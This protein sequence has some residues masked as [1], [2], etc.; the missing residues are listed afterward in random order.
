M[1][2]ST[3]FVI[4]NRV[5]SQP[6]LNLYDNNLYEEF[7][8]LIIEIRECMNLTLTYCF[9]DINMSFEKHLIFIF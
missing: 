4:E 7:E 5:F 3:I 1:A 2:K 9:V 6:T 8:S